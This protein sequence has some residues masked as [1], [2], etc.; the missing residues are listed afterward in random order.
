MYWA[1][2]HES[3]YFTLM[4]GANEISEEDLIKQLEALIFAAEKAIKVDEIIKAVDLTFNIQLS[5]DLVANWILVLKT[6][7]EHPDQIFD[8]VEIDNGY[9]F[10][11]KSVYHKAISKYLNLKSKKRLSSS[12][13]ESLAIIAYRQPV[14]KMEIERIRGVN[15]DYSVQK[16]L[17]KDLIELAGRSDAPGRPLLYRTSPQFMHHFGLRNVKDLPNYNEI[18]SEKLVIGNIDEHIEATK[19]TE[20]NNAQITIEDVV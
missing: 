10:Q 15:S 14:T 13:L 4:F 1:F 2:C 16:L 3:A 12:A 7:Y 8:L 6:K 9:L 11:T 18:V 19:T 17:E 5:V 20:E